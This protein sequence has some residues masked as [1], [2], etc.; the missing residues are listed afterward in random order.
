MGDPW[1]SPKGGNPWKSPKG[2]NLDPPGI[3]PFPLRSRGPREVDPLQCEKCGSTMRIIS[4]ITTVQQEVIDRI[5]EH[6]GISTEPP[7]ATGPPLWMQILEAQEHVQM[8][9]DWYEESDEH[10]DWAA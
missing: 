4:V 7:R 2:G 9:Q 1:K 8:Y 6:L 10:G 5:L 3:R